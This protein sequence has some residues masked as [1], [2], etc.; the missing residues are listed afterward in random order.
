MNSMIASLGILV[1]ARLCIG[2]VEIDVELTS[3]LDV[4][5]LGLEVNVNVLH[6][7]GFISM[8]AF[9]AHLATELEMLRQI[10]TQLLGRML[11]LVLGEP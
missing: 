7:L 9:S 2:L 3:Y 11:L 8:H 10:A 4:S 5:W 1:T 6:P